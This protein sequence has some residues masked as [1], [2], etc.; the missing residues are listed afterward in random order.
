MLTTE[1]DNI[2]Y[3]ARVAR[4]RGTLSSLKQQ[5]VAAL[6]ALVGR[7]VRPPARVAGYPG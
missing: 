2:K 3:A 1:C 4:Q 6:N 5:E 7:V